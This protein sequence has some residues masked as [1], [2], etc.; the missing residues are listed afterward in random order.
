MASTAQARALENY[1]ERLSKRG[2]ARFEVL[3][4]AAD[5]DLVRALAKRLAEDSPEAAE[6][7]ASLSDKIA[8]DTR[9]RG[10]ILEMLRN[11][12]L[13]GVELN[14]TRRRVNARKVDL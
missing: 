14:V 10:G 4:L 8:P 5:R 9:K 3:G 7:R 12:P 13:M 11:S 1:R 6:I 2:M